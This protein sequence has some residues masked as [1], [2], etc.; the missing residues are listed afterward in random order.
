VTPDIAE[1]IRDHTPVVHQLAIDYGE[2]HNNPEGYAHEQRIT[3]PHGV[4]WAQWA[5]EECAVIAD[6]LESRITRLYALAT[7]R[8]A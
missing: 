8:V 2:C 5:D 4:T 3:K 6:D 1:S 7:A